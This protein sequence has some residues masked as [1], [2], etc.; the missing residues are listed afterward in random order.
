M[1]PSTVRTLV[2]RKMPQLH[3][4]SPSAFD[5][6]PC[7]GSENLRRVATVFREVA[8]DC[9]GSEPFRTGEARAPRKHK[10]FRTSRRDNFL[11]F[12]IDSG[13]PQKITSYIEDE[14][15]GRRHGEELPPKI[16]DCIEDEMGG[17]RGGKWG[18]GD[19]YLLLQRL[20]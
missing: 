12:S 9:R 7:S 2:P 19:G 11:C 15:G 20:T 1:K 16:T 13:A 17:R 8:I 10:H 5:T 6:Q 3:C 18:E 4:S 14:M